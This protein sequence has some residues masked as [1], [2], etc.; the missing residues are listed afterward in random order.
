MI[1]LVEK[2]RI[3]FPNIN[4]NELDESIAFVK[5]SWSRER[6]IRRADGEI[7]TNGHTEAQNSAFLV[8][9]CTPVQKM[10]RQQDETLDDFDE[11]V[12]RVGSMADNIYFEIESINKLFDDLDDD[13][14]NAE[15]KLGFILPI[16]I[17]HRCEKI[18]GL[19]S[20]V[21][22][23]GCRILFRL[24]LGLGSD[25]VWENFLFCNLI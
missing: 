21:V 17:K 11:A 1:K 9:N 10:I 3:R 8:D 12:I 13:L 25:R 4:D 2:Q 6:P 16:P 5:K 23:N 24:H 7:N 18:Q 15:E 19:I 14:Q 20:I 22:C